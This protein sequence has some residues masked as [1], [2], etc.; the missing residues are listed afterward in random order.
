MFLKF[1][2][3]TYSE[4]HFVAQSHGKSRQ[5]GKRQQTQLYDAQQFPSVEVSW[6][7]HLSGVSFQGHCHDFGGKEYSKIT[8]FMAIFSISLL[9]VNQWTIQ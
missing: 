1:K 8:L 3:S 7:N 9:N 6:P 5:D 4:D 2:G